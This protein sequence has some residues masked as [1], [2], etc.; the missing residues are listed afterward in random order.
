[1]SED[2][3]TVTPDSRPYAAPTLYSGRTSLPEILRQELLGLHPRLHLARALLAPFPAFVASRLRTALLRGIGFAI[4][5]GTLLADVPTLSGSGDIYAKLQIGA[6][7]WLNVG[8]FFE[9]GAE[10]TI[11]DFVAIGQQVMILTTT[12]DV[13]PSD[14]RSGSIRQ[15]PVRIGS[16]AWLGARSTILPG[17]TVG[18][19]AVVAAGALVNRDVPA[20]TLVAGVPARAVKQLP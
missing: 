7:C 18:Q 11:E 6:M 14:W 5:R 9:L 15:L 1:L 16:G 8:C 20:N 17:V 2:A 12:H 4:G 13:G 3:N 19:G 10:I